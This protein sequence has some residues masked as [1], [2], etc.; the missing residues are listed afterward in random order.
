MISNF[1]STLAPSCSNAAVSRAHVSLWAAP[2]QGIRMSGP[3]TQLCMS[4]ANAKT[5]KDVAGP[6]F[7]DPL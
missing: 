3:A 7:E 6:A 5:R 1:S 4:V 2:V